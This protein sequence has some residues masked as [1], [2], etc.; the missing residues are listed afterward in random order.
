MLGHAND[1]HETRLISDRHDKGRAIAAL[2]AS[3]AI[4]PV[5]D[6]LLG[7]YER[8]LWQP[9]AVKLMILDIPVNRRDVSGVR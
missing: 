2:V 3:P 9:A 5:S 6:E 8:D 4:Q 1:A 7:G